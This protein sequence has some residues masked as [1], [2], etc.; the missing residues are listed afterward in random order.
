[1]QMKPK[2][3]KRKCVSFKPLASD[4]RNRSRH[5]RTLP[6]TN[7]SMISQ[8]TPSKVYDDDCTLLPLAACHLLR[9]FNAPS[10]PHAYPIASPSPQFLR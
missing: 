8:A 7:T 5:P 1:M 6:S 10:L 9:V 3:K 2:Q 4:K